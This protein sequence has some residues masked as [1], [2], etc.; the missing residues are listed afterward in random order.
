MSAAGVIRRWRD[1]PNAFVRECLRLEPDAWQDEV[2][3][4][5]VSRQRLA[6]KASKGPGKSALLA[7]LAWWWLATRLHP[8]IVATSITG[9]NLADGLWSELSRWQQ[10]SPFLQA[11][12]TWTATR[13][14][15]NQHKET[16]FASARAWPK[17]GDS[18][19]QA[20]T[21]AGIHADA[22]MFIID[23]AGG[24]PD[25][26]VAAAEAGL[27]NVDDAAGREARLLIAGNP[28]HLSGPLYRACTTER[29]L[30]WVKEISG[31]P[32][33]PGRA[34][35]VSVQWAREQIQKYGRDNPWVLVNVFGKF[36]PRQS[37]VLLGPDEVTA[38]VARVVREADVEAQA[39]VMALDVA[40]F[41][42][43]ES[44]LVLRQGRA[45]YRP[46]AWRNLD[47]VQLAGQVALMLEKHQPDACFIDTSG[48]GGGVYD[49]LRA[50]GHR[51]M[52]V[53]FG[54][55][56]VE[57]DRFLNKRA[58]MWWRMADWVR[59]EGALP[60][61]GELRAQLPGPIYSFTADGKVKLES[62][63]DMKKRGL[64]SPDRADALAMTFAAT[65][66]K[67]GTL[68]SN[69]PRTTAE[70]NPFAAGGR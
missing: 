8:K 10:R 44:V 41:G 63:E 26:V 19:A 47:T 22:V 57:A 11:A 60:D 54:A 34:P 70:W 45:L 15:A 17:T 1:S 69:S 13:V 12:F 2:L 46:T 16:W 5:A 4:A 58:E 35:R 28:T 18:A 31:D 27:A 37:N 38:A 7:M 62:K 67:R 3:A 56:A 50:Q 24:I 14:F 52:S 20:D 40:R 9:D 39:K 65:V 43:D 21:L 36:P 64:P 49:V 6:L 30:W 51:V 66:V 55:A 29:N 61:D 53:D 33:D 68:E 42:D 23:E 48:I 25:A 59:A 32:D